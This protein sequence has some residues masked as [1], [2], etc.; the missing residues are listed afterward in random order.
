MPYAE[1][2]F[3]T[4]HQL[5]SFHYRKA[6]HLRAFALNRPDFSHFPLY[7]VFKTLEIPRNLELLVIYS[8]FVNRHLLL[9]AQISKFFKHII[10][11]SAR[12]KRK[13]LDL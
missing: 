7:P 1:P 13:N 8:D 2:F 10:S 11:A 12:I 5:H 3:Q 4:S 9:Q 6:F